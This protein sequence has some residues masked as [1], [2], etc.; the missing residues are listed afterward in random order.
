M[1]FFPARSEYHSGGVAIF[2][3][4]MEDCHDF[5][6]YIFSKHLSYTKKST[7][8]TPVLFSLYT[9]FAFCLLPQ[10]D[11]LFTFTNLAHPLVVLLRTCTK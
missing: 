5:Y 1:S 9:L 8:N 7:G 4:E 11:Y 6:H 2:Y 10:K 3:F